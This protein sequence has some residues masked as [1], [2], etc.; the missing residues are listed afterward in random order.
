MATLL[1]PS[2]ARY[3]VATLHLFDLRT[4]TDTPTA[5]TIDADSMQLLGFAPGGRSL[6]WITY[7]GT[8]RI[9]G[10]IPGYA[11]YHYDLA[12]HRQTRLRTWSTSPVEWD[13]RLF[14]RE[15]CRLGSAC[16]KASGRFL[17]RRTC[18]EDADRIAAGRFIAKLHV[19]RVF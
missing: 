15:S 11:L 12:T 8:D 19:I 4:G 16:P 6:F 7:S 13:V 10:R 18:W 2:S 1:W 17:G 3:A 9:N 14:A 5:A